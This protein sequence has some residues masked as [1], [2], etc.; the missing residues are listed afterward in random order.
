[1][2]DILRK[3]RSSLCLASAILLLTGC[4]SLNGQNTAQKPPSQP[5]ESCPQYATDLN[6]GVTL[7]DP[8]SL[9]PSQIVRRQKIY[10]PFYSQLYPPEG[11]GQRLDLRG[12][13]SI[14]NT[15]ETDEIRIT[16]VHYFNSDG[17]LVKKCL[18]GK[19]SVLS[20]L[21]TTEFGITRQDDSGGSGANFIVEWVSEKPVS[22]PVV[23]AIMITFSG[24]HSYGFTSSGRV[25]EELK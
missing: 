7:V 16:R 1:M 15:S 14:R 11:F 25:I 20:P 10:V 13:L 22:D 17:T 21:A 4:Q 6:A 18:E 3:I 8:E 12:T 5:T 9:N 23:E 19:H 2:K 24:T